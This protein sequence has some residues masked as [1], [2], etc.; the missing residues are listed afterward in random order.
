[1]PPP[2]PAT[3]SLAQALTEEFSAKWREYVLANTRARWRILGCGIAL[4]AG[5]RL[6]GL[7]ATSWWF[8]LACAVGFAGLNYAISRIARETPFRTWYARANIAVGAAMISAVAYAV[9]P[10]GDLLFAAYLIA[11]F[12]AAYYLGPIEAWQAL[13]LNVAA[14]ALVTALRA[15]PQGWG[16]DAFVIESSVLVFVCVAL[17]PMLASIVAR[18]RATREVLAQVERGDLTARVADMERDELGYLGV[19]VNRTTAALAD[20][21]SEAQRQVAD[22]TGT[23]QRLAA[24]AAAL[25]TASQE[26]STTARQLSEGTERQRRLIGDGREDSEA[27]AGVAAA[28]HGRAQEAER[29]IGA[30]AQQARSHGEE[31]ARAGELLVAL[32]EHMNEVSG[33][34][35]TLE[36]GSREIGKLVDSMTRIASQTDLLALNAAIE[37]ARAGE[38]GLGFRVVAA[39]VRKLSEQS[40]RSADEVRSRVQG[41]QDHVAA[42]LAAMDAARRTAEGVGAV[43]AAVRTALEAILADLNTTVHF[44]TSFAAETEGQAGRIREVTRRMLDA[45]AIAETAARG[46]Q[47]ATAATE[48]QLAS[49]GELTTASQHLAAATTRL[50]ETIRRFRT[51]GAAPGGEPP[52]PHLATDRD[53]GSRGPGVAR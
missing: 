17:I 46:A 2:P 23:A 29:Q 35:G 30:I 13:G 1:M 49:L 9:G 28:L 22:L 11:P 3:P 14:F 53:G 47:Q 12:Q 5:A 41:I 21:V 15:G 19:T 25:R 10:S 42:L 31:I 38:H 51:N 44:A 52:L 48:Q 36:Q 26:I 40:A 45:G 16:W 27:A 43:S 8:I 39:E 24:P 7:I 37:A 20:A 34:A 32:V 33:A 4:L 50:T 6:V 18:V